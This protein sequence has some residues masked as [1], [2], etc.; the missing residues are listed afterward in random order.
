MSDPGELNMLPRRCL[1]CGYDLRGSPDDGR[2]PECGKNYD[3]GTYVWVREMSFLQRWGAAIAVLVFDAVFLGLFVAAARSGALRGQPIG[4]PLAAIVIATVLGI[5][6]VT[7]LLR[8]YRLHYEYV[9]LEPAGVRFR[10][11]I[12][13]DSSRATEAFLPWDKIT[14]ISPARFDG[15]CHLEL[16]PDALA[17]PNSRQPGLQV[18]SVAYFNNPSEVVAFAE[19][20]QRRKLEQGA[21]ANLGKPQ[22]T[23]RS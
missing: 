11:L 5:P 1:A 23:R 4:T 21:R 17:P 18:L 22:A 20:A 19:L 8:V 6:L 16:T 15:A 12:D 9:A 2:C 10:M 14:K 13:I 7:I 3:P